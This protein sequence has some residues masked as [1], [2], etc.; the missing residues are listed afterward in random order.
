[1][2]MRVACVAVMGATALSIASGAASAQSQAYTNQPVYLYA[3]PAQDYPVVAQLPSGQ[4]VAVYGCVSGYT[5]CDVAIA[6]ARGWVYGGYLT[7][8]YQ[9]SDVPIMDYGTVI[10]LPLITF[11]IGSYWDHYYRG[12]PWYGDRGRWAN[13]PPHRPPPPPPG[14]NSPPPGGNR[15]PSA[16]PASPPPPGPSAAGHGHRPGPPQQ[17]ERPPQGQPPQQGGRPPVQGGNPS[18]P[19]PAHGGE[20]PPG[21]PPA[22]GG[23]H[24]SGGPPGGGG[25]ARPPAPSG[26]GNEGPNH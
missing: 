15:P 19:P 12:R 13:H 22:Q 24:P 18:G 4:P 10:G 20:H 7:Y 5:W 1:M 2:R 3:G 21:P 8:P 23:G 25:N 11:S 14:G 16:S 26:H 6:Q 9:G 17:G